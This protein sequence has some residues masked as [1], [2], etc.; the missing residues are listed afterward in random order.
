M[1]ARCSTDD[2]QFGL[3]RNYR[4]TELSSLKDSTFLIP[5]SKS[6]VGKIKYRDSTSYDDEFHI[7]RKILIIFRKTLRQIDYVDSMYKTSLGAIPALT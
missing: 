4:M 7:L 1:I 5:D 6:D 2:L 3:D